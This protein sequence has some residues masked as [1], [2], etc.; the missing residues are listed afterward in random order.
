[1]G[2]ANVLPFKS[3]GGGKP[4]RFY[5]VSGGGGRKMFRTRDFAI[6]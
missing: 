6:L 2:G 1:M 4:K 5:P 3:G